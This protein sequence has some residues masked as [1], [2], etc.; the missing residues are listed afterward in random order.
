MKTFMLE[1]QQCAAYLAVRTGPCQ[2]SAV[3]AADRVLDFATSCDE[4]IC[5]PANIFS[6]REVERYVLDRSDSCLEAKQVQ[7]DRLERG[8]DVGHASLG[9]LTGI[10]QVGQHGILLCLH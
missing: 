10:P 7:P 8:H 3:L 5:F 4:P 2:D 1:I 6:G 9:T